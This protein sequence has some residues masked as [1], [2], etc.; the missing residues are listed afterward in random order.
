MIHQ[1]FTQL[2]RLVAAVAPLHAFEELPERLGRRLLK[3]K[4]ASPTTSTCVKK[5]PAANGQ[6]SVRQSPR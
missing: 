2:R 5:I 1:L 4:S 6:R 3:R